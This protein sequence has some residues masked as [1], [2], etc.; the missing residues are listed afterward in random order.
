MI[1]DSLIALRVCWK[2]SSFSFVF[3]EY[4]ANKVTYTPGV[5][6]T[7]AN[8]L[9]IDIYLLS[10][11]NPYYLSTMANLYPTRQLNKLLFPQFGRPTNEI[12]NLELSSVC[13]SQFFCFVF[14]YSLM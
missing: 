3:L 10:L 11:V 9:S 1:F 4:L 13:T 5:S 6:I 14:F 12:L 8:P 2:M 7:E